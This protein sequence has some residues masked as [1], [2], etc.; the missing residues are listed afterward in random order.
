MESIRI[1]FILFCCRYGFLITG[2]RKIFGNGKKEDYAELRQGQFEYCRWEGGG[3]Q[4][5]PPRSR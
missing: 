3:G 1:S 5:F 2:Y 4:E